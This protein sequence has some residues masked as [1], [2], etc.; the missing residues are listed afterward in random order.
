[1]EDYSVECARP[2]PVI[3]LNHTASYRREE[4]A[5]T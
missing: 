5:A 3:Q 4:L 1:M 2:D